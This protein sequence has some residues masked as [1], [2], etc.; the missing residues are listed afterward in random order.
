MQ[1]HTR[2]TNRPAIVRPTGNKTNN[3]G[4]NLPA[5]QEKIPNRKTEDQDLCKDVKVE[6]YSHVF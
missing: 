5:V 4:L 1:Y 3:F 6:T 2:H